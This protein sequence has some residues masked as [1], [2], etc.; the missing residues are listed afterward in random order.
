MGNKSVI[1][2]KQGAVAQIRLNE[3]ETLNALSFSLVNELMQILEDLRT[4]EEV[5][6][7]ILSGNGKVFCAGGNIKEFPE[8]VENSTVGRAYMANSVALASSLAQIEKP[9]IA[10]VQGY[11]VGAGFS[12]ALAS[13]FV[14]AS[15]EAEFSMGFNKIGLVPDLGALYH[16]PRR[17]GMA[18]A[19]EIVYFASSI[20]AEEAKSYGIVLEITNKDNLDSQAMKLAV[21]LAGKATQAVGLAKYILNKS[22]ESS[23]EQVLQEERFAQSIA[24]TTNDHR[25]G[26]KAFQGKRKAEF[27][28]N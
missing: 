18:R 5:R 13:D 22:F 10:A 7:I 6:A 11:A 2:E 24:F 23:L 17:V 28:G 14:I 20:G 12:L 26:K 4:D 19:K 27:K 9:V 16:L 1:M 21:T 3:P 15:Q 8:G 25:E